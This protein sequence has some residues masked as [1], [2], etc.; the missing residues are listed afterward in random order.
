MELKVVGA[1]FGR[2]GTMSLK[3]ALEQLGFGPCYHMLEVFTH[4]GHAAAWLAIAKGESG[5]W[6]SLLADF[7]SV[8]DWPTTYFYRELAEAYPQAKVILT[9]RPAE[10]W[11]R[12][13]SKTIFAAMDASRGAPIADPGMQAQRDMARFII[14]RTFAN[15]FDEEHALAVYKRHNDEVK[16]AYPKDRLLVYDSDQGWAPLCAFL[17]VPIPSTP[18]PKTNSTDEFRARARLE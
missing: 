3:L 9:E 4:P 8:V 10:A 5:D 7:Q 18:Y 17:G 6:R 1:G 12:S 16:R 11:Y 13:V 15:R 14:D 2:T